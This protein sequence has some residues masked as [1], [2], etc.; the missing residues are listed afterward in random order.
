ML[1][2]LAIF[3]GVITGTNAA[4]QGLNGLPAPSSPPSFA[5]FL[6]AFGL[7]Y[8]DPTELALR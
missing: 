1:N 4:C 7:S 8:T 2:F 3:L 6:N 5:D